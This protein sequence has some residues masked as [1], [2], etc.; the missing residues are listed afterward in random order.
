MRVAVT[1]ALGFIGGWLC[2]HLSA[3]GFDVVGLVRSAHG[4]STSTSGMERRIADI[5]DPG[6][7]GA[8]FAGVDAVV[9]LAALFNNPKS[10]WD[11]Y[12]AVNVQGTLNVLKAARAAG[13]RL[14][15]HCSTVGVA[16]GS[17]KLPYSVDTP[18]ST[19]D[20]DKYET[21]KREGEQA[22]L[23]FHRETGYPVV[24]IRP[25]QVYGPGD[26]SKA[27]FYRMVK[28]GIIVNPGRTLKHLIHVDDLC[29]A[30]EAG[31]THPGA[32]GHV[33]IIAGADGPTPLKDLIRIAAAELGV[34][35]PRIVI[36]ALPVTLA[37]TVTEAVCNLLSVKPILFR[38]SMDF[39][40]KTVA[41][42]TSKAEQ[43]LGFTSRIDVPSGVKEVVAWY[44]SEGLV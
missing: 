38:R 31:I 18:Y 40:T 6:A 43:D 9:H 7:L 33:Y 12:R 17:G 14:V 26:R 5:T 39:F 30:F 42:D 22:A 20:W 28:K 13:V 34:R 8:A 41:F 29:R 2:R 21:T 19:P 23:A 25:A 37:C 32:P 4:E 11:D 36:P 10:S 16:S 1:G 44:R 24:V 15:V 3:A 35:P 27:K